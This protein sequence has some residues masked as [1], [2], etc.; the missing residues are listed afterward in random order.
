[1]REGRPIAETV[2]IIAATLI[3]RLIQV[4]RAAR[5]NKGFKMCIL[6]QLK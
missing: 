1:M 3:C 5:A 2:D 4:C 6:W